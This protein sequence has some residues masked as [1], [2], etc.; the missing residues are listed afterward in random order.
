MLPTEII[1]FY[2]HLRKI[3]P[4]R[5]GAPPTDADIDRWILALPARKSFNLARFHVAIAVAS[6]SP[7]AHATCSKALRFARMS[8]ER[9][10][11]LWAMVVDDSLKRS[12]QKS[13]RKKRKEVATARSR[14]RTTPKT[15]RRC[16]RPAYSFTMRVVGG[17]LPAFGTVRKIGS[18]RNNH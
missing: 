13:L 18:R 14:V 9:G 3:L 10:A 2:N 8:A 1:D 7:L 6:Q 15:W 16:H 11:K 17:T 5:N 12:L 4:P